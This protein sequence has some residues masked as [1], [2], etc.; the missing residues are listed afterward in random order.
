MNKLQIT[1]LLILIS[2]FSFGQWNQQNSGTSNTLTDIHLL[3]Q[4][5]VLVSGINTIL[6]TFDGGQNWAKTSLTSIF[7]EGIVFSNDSCAFGVGY[8]LDSSKSTIFSSIDYGISWTQN[9]I[10]FT[11]SLKDVFF[12][13]SNIGFCVG[14]GGTILKTMDAGLNWNLLSSGTNQG[15][16]SVFFTDS[17]NGTI[18]GG[19]IRNPLILRTTDGGINWLLNDSIGTNLLQSVFYPTP[20]IGYIVGWD[21]QVFRTDDGGIN[22]TSKQSVQNQGNLDVFFVNDSIGYIAGGN[23]DSA[24]IKKTINSGDS[25]QTYNAKAAPGMVAIHFASNN[26]G[27]CV[28]SDGLI[29]KTTVAGELNVETLENNVSLKV[30]PN[31]SLDYLQISYEN[32]SDKLEVSIV[33]LIGKV[34]IQ[35][36]SIENNSRIDLSNLIPQQYIV[37][38]KNGAGISRTKILKM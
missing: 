35:N 38:I 4:D 25:W 12:V 13:S 11:S 5:T 30:F 24:Y 15:L 34:Y 8:N 3:N 14:T 29:L 10:P 2:H 28:G 22:W 33:D 17:V 7:L 19:G 21:G 1:F 20:N 31:P 37:I 23:P 18:V 16:M 6:R 27:Y 26:I 9:I 32:C 36:L